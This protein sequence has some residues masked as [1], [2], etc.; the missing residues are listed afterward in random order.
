MPESTS[1]YA[2]SL[3]RKLAREVLPAPRSAILSGKHHPGARQDKAWPPAK[4]SRPDIDLRE[5]A[6]R[7]GGIQCLPMVWQSIRWPLEMCPASTHRLRQKL[8]FT[9][10]QI[11]VDAH[12]RL[13]A[14]LTPGDPDAAAEKT[15]I[16]VAIPMECAPST[17]AS[18]DAPLELSATV[19]L[20]R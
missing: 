1:H 11:T 5:H 7:L 10:R 6:M 16:H 17:S 3:R 15:G 8:S 2:P 9:P 19:P 12:R 18:S 13:P 20:P 14:A 4:L